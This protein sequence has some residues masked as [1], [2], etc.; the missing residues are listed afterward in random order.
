M[1][2]IQWERQR[3][4]GCGLACGPGERGTAPVPHELLSTSRLCTA[5]FR[6]FEVGS[7][8]L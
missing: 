7:Y 4:Q 2:R 5:A 6:G 3:P 1:W 8:H